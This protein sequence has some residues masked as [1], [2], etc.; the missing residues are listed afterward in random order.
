M[1]R[2]A[3]NWRIKLTS[4]AASL[5]LVVMGLMLVNQPQAVQAAGV[6]GTGSP[7]SCTEQSLA[8]A[9]T[10]GGT[11][12]FNC[13][14]A[15]TINIT[16][17]KN[18]AA[19]TVID[20]GGLITLKAT[21]GS[22]IFQTV[23][24]KD[25]TL[26]N[27][28]LRDA[29]VTNGIGG[30][31]VLG[32]NQSNIT[33]INCRFL[34]NIFSAPGGGSG[35]YGGAVFVQGATLQVNNCEF[36]GNT[37]NRGG[38]SALHTLAANVVIRNSRFY[39]N[40]STA[41]GN[42]GAFYSDNVL[43]ANGSILVEDSQFNDNTAQG[44]GGAVRNGTY[45]PTHT[46]TYNRVSFVSNSVTNAGGGASG[47]AIRIGGTGNGGSF[48]FTDSTFQS[49][50]SQGQGGAIWTGETVSL[51]ILRTTLS[52]NTAIGPDGQ[53]GM[54]GAIAINSSAASTFNLTNTTVSDN[55]AG[56]MGGGLSIG[57]QGA[58]TINNSTIVNNYA[59]WQG[60]GLQNASSNVILRNT[61]IAYNVANNGGNDWNIY[62]NCFP[63]GGKY[64]NGGNNRQYSSLNNAPG[65]ACANG[66]AMGA[67]PKVAPLGNNGGR[68]QTRALLPGSPAIN[69]GN[70]ATCAASDQRNL[71]RPIG[72]TC[73]IGA[74]EVVPPP[75]LGQSFA[76][77]TIAP[78]GSSSLVFT[79]INPSAAPLSGL[80]FGLTLPGGLVVAAN[81]LV[82]NNCSL[83]GTVGASPGSASLSLN[84]AGL[85][86]N[87][88]CQISVKIT[89]STAGTYTVGPTVLK[90]LEA[91]PGPASSG[92]VLK[93]I[94]LQKFA[95]Y[96][97]P[98]SPL[99]MGVTG[100]G[101]T[102]TAKFVVRNEGDPSSTLTVGIGSF[103]GNQ[104]G[105]FSLTSPVATSVQ[106]AG[107]SSQT[108][109]LSC[110]PQALGTRTATLNLTSNDP[111]YPAIA[112][113]LVCIGGY[114]VTQAADDGNAGITGSL[115]EILRHSANTSGQG[116]YFEVPG[117]II[118]FSQPFVQPIPAG[119]TLD[120]GC[121]A[122]G[123]VI[124]LNGMG[125]N[126]IGLTLSGGNN[127]LGLKIINFGKQPIL[128]Q[129]TNGRNRFY[130]VEAKP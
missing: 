117:N 74:F 26:Q 130:C 35:D 20:G 9:L 4:L 7:A 49:N 66:I 84:G 83:P 119:V 63:N 113:Q 42:G 128:S 58:F 13:G 11:V 47:G 6:V 17:V 30:A 57:S 44:E 124:T 54:G 101:N 99:I 115:S 41:P 105:D 73:D 24:Q 93:I 19:S 40:H 114:K 12:T 25:L 38:G 110:Q 118:N 100:L 52:Y 97:G 123:P 46:V 43:N 112:Y 60:G 81:P 88:T 18:I 64:T 51:N 96:P 107:G 14:G 104:P 80:N 82:T 109:A 61:I 56:F 45:V 8:T 108:F 85:A 111:N 78:N 125:V 37:S 86:A 79:L 10:G 129:A 91:G 16:S 33:L 120:G 22:R 69:A 55:R 87:Q 50:S 70:N 77:A 122:N 68:N 103:S 48:N 67:D 90:S 34:N 36:S 76:P 98:G 116:V 92:T 28:T 121:G 27:I 59:W 21:G 65:E 62:H 72:G 127:L 126:G 15:A 39:S 5:M 106:L 3:L 32:A 53:S 2:K 71:P 75:S 89:G 95:A 1:L 102:K 23:Y 29:N 94:Q 31:A